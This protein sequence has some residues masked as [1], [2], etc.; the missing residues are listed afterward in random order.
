VLDERL[1]IVE[2]DSFVPDRHIHFLA[3]AGRPHDASQWPNPC[4]QTGYLS[5][6]ATFFKLLKIRVA[7]FTPNRKNKNM[8]KR[9]GREDRTLAP[10]NLNREVPNYLETQIVGNDALRCASAFTIRF[11]NSGKTGRPQR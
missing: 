10:D 2:E 9:G 6:V 5:R 7:A 8:L 4:P 11:S 3:S 1:N